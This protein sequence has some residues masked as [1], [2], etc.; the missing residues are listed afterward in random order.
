MIVHKWNVRAF[1][2]IFFWICFIPFSSFLVLTSAKCKCHMQM[3]WFVF[4]NALCNHYA[5]ICYWQTL[6]HWPR[7]QFFYECKQNVMQAQIFHFRCKCFFLQGCRC[8]M[9]IWCTCLLSKMQFLWC[10]CLMQEMRMQSLSMMVPAH[11]FNRDANV[12]L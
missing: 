12:S 11:I 6:N 3:P 10:R 4:T 1:K 9:S 2:L 5:L 8:E 7:C